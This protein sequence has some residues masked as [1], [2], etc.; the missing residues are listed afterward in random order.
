[1]LAKQLMRAEIEA[2]ERTLE[3]DDGNYRGQ[4]SDPIV[5]P[6]APEHAADPVKISLLWLDYLKS[7][8]QA[9]LL[10]DGGKRQEPVIRNLRSYLRHDDARRVTKKDLLVWR[11]SVDGVDAPS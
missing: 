4:P 10:K 7:R 8:V 11:D 6:P 2:L 9:G 5:K 3:R 1:V